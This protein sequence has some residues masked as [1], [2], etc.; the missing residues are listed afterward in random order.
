[1]NTLLLYFKTVQKSSKVL[2]GQ[3]TKNTAVILKINSHIPYES[4][5]SSAQ[6][7]TSLVAA[8]SLLAVMVSPCNTLL[9]QVSSLTHS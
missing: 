3:K 5:R 2:I 1:V 9:S 6:L 4:S 8:G 7:I